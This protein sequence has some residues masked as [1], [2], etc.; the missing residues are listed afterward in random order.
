MSDNKWDGSDGWVEGD[1]PEEDFL[2]EPKPLYDDIDLNYGQAP[3]QVAQDWGQPVQP[4][5][6]ASQPPYAQ[7]PNQY[8]VHSPQ[9]SLSEVEQGKTMAIFCHLSV[10]FGLPIFIV[11]FIQRDNDFALHHA[12]AATVTFVSMLAALTLTVLT[13]GLAFPLLFLAYVPAIVGIVQASNGQQAGTWGFGG[14]GEAL[15]KVR[16]RPRIEHK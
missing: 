15:F 10:L 4:H 12:K 11:P 7:A 16:A 5:H 8:M 1:L 14:V 6:H 2:S 13:C 3:G 9:S